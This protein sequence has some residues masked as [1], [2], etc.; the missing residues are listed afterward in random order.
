MLDTYIR[1]SANQE[2]N[3][4]CDLRQDLIAHLDNGN[5]H[6]NIFTKL[7]KCVVELM[8]VNAFIPWISAS[9]SS[10]QSPPTSSD[11]A[12]SLSTSSSHSSPTSFSFPSFDRLSSFSKLKSPTLRSSLPAL[13]TS[14]QCIQDI[15]QEPA[16]TRYR[17]MLQR[18]KVSLQPNTIKSSWKR[19]I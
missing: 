5:F 13:D 14:T 10:P 15:L 2:I 9:H 8:R 18:V 16:S 6:P 17:T 1:S 4:P 19:S 3:I 12:P 7:N 11:M